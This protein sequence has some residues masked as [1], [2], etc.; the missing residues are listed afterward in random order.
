MEFEWCDLDL[1]KEEVEPRTPPAQESLRGLSS[2][3]R[4]KALGESAGAMNDAR[5]R[6]LTNCCIVDLQLAQSLR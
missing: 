6:G 1:M 2:G 3:S 4:Y 5:N